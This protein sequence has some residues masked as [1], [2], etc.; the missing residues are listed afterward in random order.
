MI[1]EAVRVIQT[2]RNWPL[3]AGD[4]FGVVHQ[5]RILLTLRNGTRC[6]IRPGTAD[7]GIFNEVWLHQY[8]TPAGFE[9]GPA[10]CV[11]DI[12]AHIGLFS[13]YAATRTQ[14]PI[15][16]FE[17]EPANYAVLTENIGLNAAAIIPTCAAVSD[18]AGERELS[19]SHH[20]TGWNSFYMDNATDKHTIRVATVSL[21]Q[22]VDTYQLSQVDFLKMDCEGAEYD[23]LLTSPA[24][25][26]NGVRR[27]SMEHHT[28]DADRTVGHLERFLTRQG[29]SVRIT[30]GWGG[31]LY[32][33]RSD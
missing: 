12:G 28:I 7:R 4:Y 26:L 1:S 23:I 31:M 13:L 3:Y 5:E 15:Y 19:L 8:Y 14:R 24:H 9:I 16:A 29:F 32:A 18:R 11:V 20:N 10:D 33:K 22:V 27:I 21:E 25:V 30:Y 17:P 6:V 2:V